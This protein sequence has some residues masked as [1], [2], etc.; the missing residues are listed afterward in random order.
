MYR[1]TTSWYHISS[2]GSISKITT[3][4][5]SKEEDGIGSDGNMGNIVKQELSQEPQVMVFTMGA[6]AA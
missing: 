5:Q 4:E 1:G 3:L 6:R 2:N